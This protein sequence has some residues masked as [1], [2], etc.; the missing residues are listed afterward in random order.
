MIN[1]NFKTHI[2]KVLEYWTQFLLLFDVGLAICRDEIERSQR[3][4]IQ[5]GRFTL[6][7]KDK[8]IACR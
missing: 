4:L 1:I 7:L 8:L 2:E 5:V 3:I 6:N